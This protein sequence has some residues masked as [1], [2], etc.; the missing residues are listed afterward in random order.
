MLR[1]NFVD[2]LTEFLRVAVELCEGAGFVPA[3]PLWPALCRADVL[4]VDAG[5][6]DRWVA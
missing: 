1:A 2:L 3:A 5:V 4:A 6:A